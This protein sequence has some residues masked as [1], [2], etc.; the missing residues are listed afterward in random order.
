MSA[1]LSEPG[2]PVFGN[3]PK[4]WLDLLPIV[5]ALTGATY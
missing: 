1:E 2:L 3:V 4:S 5:E